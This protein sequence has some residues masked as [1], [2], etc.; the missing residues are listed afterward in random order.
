MF[1][2]YAARTLTVSMWIFN[3]LRRKPKPLVAFSG[4]PG[5]TAETAVVIQAETTPLGTI[6]EYLYIEKVCGRR[7]EDWKQ[8]LQ[9]VK[10]MNGK[11]YDFH[12]IEMKDGSRRELWFDITSFYG[13]EMMELYRALHDLRTLG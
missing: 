11:M 1:G 4:G 10:G 13:R 8:I 7:D 12:I 6:A 5:D 3:W 9:A 2:G